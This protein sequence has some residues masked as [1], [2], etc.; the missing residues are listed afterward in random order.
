LSAN[1]ATH[2][3]LIEKQIRIKIP[4]IKWIKRVSIIDI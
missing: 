3:Y 1:V 4:K 2:R